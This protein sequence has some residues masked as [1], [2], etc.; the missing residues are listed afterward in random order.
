M[1]LLVEEVLWLLFF[2]FFL[3]FNLEFWFLLIE[4]HELG[5][6]ELWLL[7]ELDLSNEDVLEGEDLSTL[8]LDFLSNS[9][10]NTK[11]YN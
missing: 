10:G 2:G 6:I 8:L 7:K 5:K 4:F 1:L 3:S 9:V 11:R